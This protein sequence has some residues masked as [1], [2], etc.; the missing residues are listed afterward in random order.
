MFPV[1]HLGNNDNNQQQ[2]KDKEDKDMA[3]N[4]DVLALQQATFSLDPATG[5]V[6]ITNHLRHT[7]QLHLGLL[8]K[9]AVAFEALADEIPALSRAHRH[10]D[11]V[12]EAMKA[13]DVG[14]V[15][16][17]MVLR[18]EARKLNKRV[19]VG[20]GIYEVLRSGK[21][22]YSPETNFRLDLHSDDLTDICRTLA[23]T[24]SA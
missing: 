11:S 20:A 17:Y 6:S 21:Y 12:K 7:F 15:N 10:E 5:L 4:R 23:A 1:S 3:C 13:I 14:R 22:H 2:R 19:Y 18:I 9:L 16:S 24:V 8:E